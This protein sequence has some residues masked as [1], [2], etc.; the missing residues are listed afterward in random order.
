MRSA[1]SSARA[2]P[3]ISTST[4][5]AATVCFVHLP[6]DD[7]TEVRVPET[8]V[9]TAAGDTAASRLMTRARAVCVAG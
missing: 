1:V 5:S 4:L 8:A 2:L 3:L 6:V 9:D 7:A